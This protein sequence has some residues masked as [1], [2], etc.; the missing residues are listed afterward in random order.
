MLIK[1][2]SIALLCQVECVMRAPGTCRRR[3][4]RAA[5]SVAGGRGKTQ[6]D[7]QE[8]DAMLGRKRECEKED[9]AR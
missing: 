2:M 4:E 6:I 8:R 5:V 9:G 3:R 1:A 7:C